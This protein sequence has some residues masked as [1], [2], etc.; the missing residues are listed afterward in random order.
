[1]LRQITNTAVGIVRRPLASTAVSCRGMS[2]AVSVT[3]PKVMIFSQFRDD[4]TITI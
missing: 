1:M 3:G 2:A 4:P